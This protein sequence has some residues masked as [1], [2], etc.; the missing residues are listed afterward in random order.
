LVLRLTKADTIIFPVLP[1]PIDIEASIDY[2]DNLLNRSKIVAKKAKIALV[3]NRIKENTLS[4]DKLDQYLEK[5]KIPYV[6][7]LRESQN[8]IKCFEKGLSI[9]ELAPYQ[10]YTDSEQWQPLINWLESARSQPTN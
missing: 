2:L 5:Q 7:T 4:F 8:Y 3:A 9:Y 6:V 1:S 10:A